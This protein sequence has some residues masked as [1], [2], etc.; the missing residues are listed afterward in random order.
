VPLHRA[1]AEEELGPDLRVR[2][3]AGG[4]ARDLGLLRGQLVERLDRA[5]THGLAGGQQLAPGALGE[6]LHAD[7]REHH[8]RDSQLLTGVDATVLAPQ[9]LAV[10]EVRAGQRGTDL[11]AR[12]PF[13]R[14]LVEPLGRIP[15]GQHRCRAREGSKRPVR[16]GGLRYLSELGERTGRT[17][18]LAAARGALDQLGQQP[19]R[20]AQ[21]A[22]G[23]GGVLGRG[24]GVLVPAEPV[25]ANRAAP[26][27]GDEPEPFAAPQHILP[28]LLDERQRHVVPS[29]PVLQHD[30]GA[31]GQVTTGRLDHGIG[32]GGQGHG[33]LRPA[34]E[35]LD[36]HAVGEREGQ[37]G[38][39][40]G[41]ARD[42]EMARG[43]FVPRLIVGQRPGDA[44]GQPQPA[45]LVLL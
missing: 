13:D 35:Q 12:Q 4:Q 21:P 37:R 22:R 17:L 10:Q 32:L 29:P 14:L 8:V 15:L 27:V 6:R 25:V 19:D 1:R 26:V 30:R 28:P 5:L 3:P 33:R 7:V 20:R 11:D 9:P 43:E 42:V 39:R 24:H 40:A 41:P 31:Q 36:E 44:A 45:Q 16:A 2:L 38:E 23:L 34:G 18:R